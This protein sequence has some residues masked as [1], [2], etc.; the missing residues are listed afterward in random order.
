MKTVRTSLPAAILTFAFFPF[1]WSA[2]SPAVP[3][4]TESPAAALGKLRSK[5]EAQHEIVILLIRKKDFAQAKVEAA[6]IFDM[7]WPV[8]QEPLLLKE[9]LL[10]SSQFVHNGQARVGLELLEENMRVFRTTESH[11]AIWKERGYL[12]KLMKDTDKALD[13]FREARRLEK[14]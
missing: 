1:L 4:Q 3:A 2:G 9:L 5:A 12:H 13:C 14:P 7:K 11:I 6:K 10:L 8:D